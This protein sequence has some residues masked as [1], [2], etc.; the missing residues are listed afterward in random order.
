[1]YD[2]S[3][4]DKG[5]QW[6]QQLADGFKDGS[7]GVID[8]VLDSLDI[9]GAT[10]SANRNAIKL[11][12]ERL[13]AAKRAWEEAYARGDV[14]GMEAAARLGQSIRA[15]GPTLDPNNE[16]SADELEEAIR[17][18]TFHQGGKTLKAGFALL[19]KGERVLS[20]SLNSQLERFFRIG[21]STTTIHTRR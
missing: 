20:A 3:W 8:S 9:G 16:M 5:L 10:A 11:R 12:S 6:A 17:N 15:A 18:A 7:V 14:A 1:M 4:Y 21:G 19:D 2:Q 13:L